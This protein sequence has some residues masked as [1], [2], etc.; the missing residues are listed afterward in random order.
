MTDDPMDDSDADGAAAVAPLSPWAAEVLGTDAG[1]RRLAVLRLVQAGDYV[2]GLGET[3]AMR[4]AAGAGIS[5]LEWPDPAAAQL[6]SLRRELAGLRK[7]FT[8]MNGAAR[9]SEV[10]R[11]KA[12]A[13][14]VPV[15]Q[16]SLDQFAAAH[17]LGRGKASS[18]D[19]DAIRTAAAGWLL[20]P[21]AH[22]A[23]ERFAWYDGDI[24]RNRIAL[25]GLKNDDAE[26]FA[27]VPGLGHYLAPIDPRIDAGD[28]PAWRRRGMERMKAEVA[29]LD[30][31]S[32]H[33]AA[34]QIL[35]A[36]GCLILFILALTSGGASKPPPKP[37][38]ANDS[39]RERGIVPRRPGETDQQYEQRLKTAIQSK[40]K[41]TP[42]VFK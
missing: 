35:I 23:A 41:T 12:L 29:P 1:D 10:A 4:Q 15:V 3:L 39:F 32:R 24:D 2:P 26:L 18:A 19:G 11:V 6:E 20:L 42:P 7:A 16:R 37:P 31:K 9:K 25:A 5:A 28:L 27:A 36:C 38:D 21:P 40:N 14:Q 13:Q 17:K 22:F 33:R 30:R 8:T 34:L